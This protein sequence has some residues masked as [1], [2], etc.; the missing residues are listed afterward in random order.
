MIQWDSRTVRTY[1]CAIFFCDLPKGHVNE[2]SKL[3]RSETAKRSASARLIQ[4]RTVNVIK[5]VAL[6]VNLNTYQNRP[7]QP[8]RTNGLP[9]NCVFSPARIIK[10]TCCPMEIVPSSSCRRPMPGRWLRWLLALWP[11]ETL[12]FLRCRWDI[13]GFRMYFCRIERFRMA[14]LKM[15]KNKAIFGTTNQTDQT[16]KT[17]EK[18]ENCKKSCVFLCAVRRYIIMSN[19]M[20]M[21]LANSSHLS[22]GERFSI[23]LNIESESKWSC[24]QSSRSDCITAWWFSFVLKKRPRCWTWARKWANGPENIRK[25]GCWKLW[26]LAMTSKNDAT[27]TTMT[28]EPTSSKPWKTHRFPGEFF[29]ACTMEVNIHQFRWNSISMNWYDNIVT[30]IYM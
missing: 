6:D 30:Y 29:V 23:F 2:T 16:H 14:M 24:T 5:D 22:Q 21:P 15:L 28:T 17:H 20:Q 25:W 19:I 13:V 9:P 4:E 1:V 26:G 8:P 12:T 7:N 11:F 18:P 10:N 3:S 27:T